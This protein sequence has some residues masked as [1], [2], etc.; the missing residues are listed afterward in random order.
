MVRYAVP[1]KFSP[2][3]KTNPPTPARLIP[4]QKAV[5]SNRARFTS[6]Y[7]PSTSFYIPFFFLRG[8]WGGRIS[9][10]YN[11][12]GLFFFY[13]WHLGPPSLPSIRCGEYMLPSLCRADLL[14]V[15]TTEEGP[16]S[17]REGFPASYAGCGRELVPY[18]GF[19]PP[20]YIPPESCHRIRTSS[21]SSSTTAVPPPR[22]PPRA[23]PPRQ[24]PTR[25]RRSGQ[26]VKPKTITTELASQSAKGSRLPTTVPHHPTIPPA[27]GGK[28]WDLGSTA[29]LFTLYA[30]Q[31]RKLGKR[32]GLR[33]GRLRYQGPN[34]SIGLGDPVLPPAPHEPLSN[35]SRYF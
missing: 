23:E 31:E 15:K 29:L 17:S 19:H 13:N 32:D 10:P 6:F 9:V 20:F 22:L 33:R 3:Q 16:P 4:D 12:L 5:R 28:P 24:A 35:L 27:P 2:I 26:P 34:D 11:K 21:T 14:G 8:G 1:L 18:S 7:H 30:G 25:A